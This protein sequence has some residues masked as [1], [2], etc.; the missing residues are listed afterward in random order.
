MVDERSTINE[1]DVCSVIV[2]DRVSDTW[3][4][5]SGCSFHMCPKRKY[6]DTYRAC[7]AST[8]MMGN[9]SA[10]RVV[11]IGTVKMKMFDGVVRT[12]A[13]VRHVPRLRRGLI[14]LGVLD[15]LGCDVFVKNGTMSAVRGAS[16]LMKGE[17]VKNL[18]MLIGEPV[19]GGAMK[20]EPRSEKL[21]YVAKKWVKVSD[22][23]KS[24]GRSEENKKVVDKTN[25][26]STSY[27]I[28]EEVEDKKIKAMC[29]KMK[30]VCR[31]KF[32]ES[33]NSTHFY[34]D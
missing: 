16:T 14:S 1:G 5:D 20:V 10:S 24:S 29:K 22:R 13:N 25:V 27:L 30:S 4:L 9:G 31:V 3:I 21:P 15:T 2:D 34:S 18:F 12:L 28:E 17:K 8:V 32:D 33:L 11:G 23:N 19:V 26:A 7:D 6:F